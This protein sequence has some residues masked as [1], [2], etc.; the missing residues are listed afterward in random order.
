M[1]RRLTAI[2]AADVVG[3]SR[4]MGEDEVGTLARLKTCRRELIDPAIEEFHGRIVKLMGDGALVEFASVVDAVQCAAAIQRRM[5]EHDQGAAEARQIR[6]RIGVNL[7]DIIVEE[8]IS[9]ATAS[10]SP[11]AWR[12]WRSPAASASPARRS[13][14]RCTRWMS[15]LPVWASS[16]SRTSPIRFASI[17]F[18]SIPEKP[19]RSWPRHAGRVPRHDSGAESQRCSSRVLAGIVHVQWQ[20]PSAPQRP[21]VA[22]LPFANLSGDPSQDY[23]ADGI[24]EDLITDLAKLSGLDVIARNSVFAYKG[25]PVVLADVGARSWCPLSSL[26]AACGGPA[27]KSA[28]MRSSST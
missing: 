28:S 11:R 12:R 13:I 10:T 15:A 4:L 21:S 23:F 25:K 27:S 7:G 22:V 16:A 5:A 2:L 19:G 9:T 3:Y 8:T 18:C 17:G 14:T 6:F 20:K 1:E 26:K 24:T